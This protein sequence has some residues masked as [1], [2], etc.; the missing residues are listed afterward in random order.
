MF[1][2]L[3]IVT[4]LGVLEA[5]AASHQLAAFEMCNQLRMCELQVKAHCLNICIHPYA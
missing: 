5:Y 4:V 3:T 2:Q 1:E